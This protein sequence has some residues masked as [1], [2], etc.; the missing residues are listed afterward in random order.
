LARHK[1]DDRTIRGPPIVAYLERN[2]GHLTL[3]RKKRLP[4]K[5]RNRRDLSAEA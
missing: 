4:E 3:P 2:V 5:L 1:N